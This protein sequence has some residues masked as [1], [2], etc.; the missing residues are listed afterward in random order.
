MNV[1]MSGK[2]VLLV[3]SSALRSAMICAAW[4]LVMGTV[5]AVGDF[6]PR[7]TRW[8]RIANVPLVVGALA[9]LVTA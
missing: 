7:S 9:P 3:F 2:S 4:A 5:G 8:D 1:R 6:V